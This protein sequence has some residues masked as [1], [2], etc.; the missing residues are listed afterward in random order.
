MWVADQVDNKLYAYHGFRKT[1][2]PNEDFNSL[3]A[4]ANHRPR[5]IWSNG[6]TMWVA[7]NIKDKLFAYDLATKERAEDKEFTLKTSETD[8]KFP[9]AFGR[10]AQQCGY[11]LL[12]EI[13]LWTGQMARP[14]GEM[15]TWVST[16]IH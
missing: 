14:I 15:M 2:N 1:L 13:V 9:Q 10:M 5:G 3:S 4:A 8:D 12:T 7:D 11:H 6:A 16:P